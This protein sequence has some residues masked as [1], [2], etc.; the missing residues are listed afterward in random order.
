MSAVIIEIAEN[1]SLHR[2]QILFLKDSAYANI[3]QPYTGYSTQ[4][5]R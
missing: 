3:R 5:Q 1:F 2:R 4:L